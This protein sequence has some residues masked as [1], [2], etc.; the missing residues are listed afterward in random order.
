MNDPFP[1]SGDSS[2]QKTAPNIVEIETHANDEREL[3]G[4]LHEVS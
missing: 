3:L 2:P 4:Q 1:E